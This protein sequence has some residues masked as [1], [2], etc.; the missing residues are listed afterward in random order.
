MFW[1]KQPVVPAQIRAGVE[2]EQQ[3]VK[4]LEFQLKELAT[5]AAAAV[6]KAESLEQEVQML[7]AERYPGEHTRNHSQST[8]HSNGSFN[9]L[10][11]QN[12]SSVEITP[13]SSP[14]IPQHSILQRDD[15]SFD[16]SDLQKR[17]KELQKINLELNARLGKELELRQDCEKRE[18]ALTA[19]IEDLSVSVFEEAN[20]KVQIE[21]K[22]CHAYEEKLQRVTASSLERDQ[23]W[24]NI[25]IAI[26]AIRKARTALN[27]V[28][29]N[30]Y[31]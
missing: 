6:D 3:R 9:S 15:D 16:I 4:D 31:I 11:S 2:G 5:T 19:Q 20:R 30:S 23:R 14:T 10:Y 27:S 29:L 24:H 26:E 22:K 18:K 7:R 17:I 21:R 1:S 8:A 28:H 13:M 12:E 25:E